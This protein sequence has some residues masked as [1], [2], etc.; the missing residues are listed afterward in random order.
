MGKPN[1]LAIREIDYC[2]RSEVVVAV[3]LIINVPIFYLGY[4]HCNI[5]VRVQL[6]LS[7]TRPLR[8]PPAHKGFVATAALSSSRGRG[9]A[10]CAIR[11]GAAASPR[12]CD[13][14]RAF[15]RA[16][17]LRWTTCRDISFVARPPKTRTVTAPFYGP[18]LC[19]H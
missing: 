2:F 7:F 16:D 5:N 13:T 15:K 3:A 14:S 19:C 6:K 8:R 9:S 10:L 12:C 11:A 4:Y 17:C 1:S 18:E